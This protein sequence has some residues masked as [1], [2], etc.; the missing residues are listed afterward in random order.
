M[1][2]LIA[3]T[4]PLLL[5][6]V[7]VPPSARQVSRLETDV[8]I[9]TRDDE[10]LRHWSE[11]RPDVTVDSVTELRPGTPAQVVVRVTGCLADAGA[12]NVNVDYTIYRPDNSVFKELKLQPVENG[13]TPP[14]LRFTLAASDPAGLYRVVATIRDLNARRMQRPERIFSLRID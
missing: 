4:L 10:T 8:I 3:L 7:Q 6:F 1:P 2:V 9:A 11:G 12:C 5:A 13:K 14:P